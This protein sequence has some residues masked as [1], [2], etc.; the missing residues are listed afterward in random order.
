MFFPLEK[1]RTVC[2]EGKKK[3][4]TLKD[5]VPLDRKRI[6]VL[7][8]S[9]HLLIEVTQK[10]DLGRETLIDWLYLPVFFNASL[11]LVCLFTSKLQKGKASLL[12]A[13]QGLVLSQRAQIILQQ[14]PIPIWVAEADAEWDNQEAPLSSCK[15]VWLHLYKSHFPKI[16]NSKMLLL[17]GRCL[18]PPNPKGVLCGWVKHCQMPLA[19]HTKKF[20]LVTNTRIHLHGRN[21]LTVKAHFST[22]QPLLKFWLY[23]NHT[24]LMSLWTAKGEWMK[25]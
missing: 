11:N 13:A 1:C 8:A 25:S 24:P 17:E 23:M 6:N 5:H 14:Q 4:L 10:E 22:N 16:Y 7:Y 19:L 21:S 20:P 2:K 15:S 9:F 3:S 18:L 12:Y